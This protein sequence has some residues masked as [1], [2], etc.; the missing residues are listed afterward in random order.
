MTKYGMATK[1]LSSSSEVSSN[2]ES[3]ITDNNEGSNGSNLPNLS[4]TGHKLNGHC[5]NSFPLDLELEKNKQWSRHQSFLF[6]CDWPPKKKLMVFENKIWV[7]EYDYVS[8]RY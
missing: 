3:S 4:I 5:H 6:R 1:T 8:R 2:S 7:R